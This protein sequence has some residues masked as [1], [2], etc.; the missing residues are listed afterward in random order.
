[1][2]DRESLAEVLL[3][4]T[5]DT[6][7]GCGGFAG[8]V[9]WAR[10]PRPPAAPIVQNAPAKA[11]PLSPVCFVDPTE[12]LPPFRNHHRHQKP[13]KLPQSQSM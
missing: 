10:H 6:A 4:L 8:I 1:M 2:A 7:A 13:R 3:L 12:K 5:C 11:L 9:A